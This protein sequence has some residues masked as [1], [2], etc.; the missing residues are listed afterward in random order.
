VIKRGAAA[1]AA[2][3]SIVEKFARNRVANKLMICGFK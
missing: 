3:R 1:D 2:M